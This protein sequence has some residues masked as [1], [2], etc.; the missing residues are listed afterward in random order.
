MRRVKPAIISASRQTRFPESVRE[1]CGKR[2]PGM[3]WEEIPAAETLQ[4][5]RAESGDPKPKL[6][7]QC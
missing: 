3:G 4:A 5:T 2:E 6:I 1:I 7:P